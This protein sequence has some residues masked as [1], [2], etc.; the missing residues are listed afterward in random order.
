MIEEESSESAIINIAINIFQNVGI[1]RWIEEI[2]ILK[3]SQI[4]F[5]ICK[6][7]FP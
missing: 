7:I 6:I 4:Y 5:E 3:S 2:E 1:R